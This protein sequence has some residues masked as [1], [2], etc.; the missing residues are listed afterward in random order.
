MLNIQILRRPGRAQPT[1]VQGGKAVRYLHQLIKI[2]ADHDNRRAFACQIHQRLP[3]RRGCG[4]VDT[5]GRLVH[6]QKLWL[7]QNFATDHKLLQVAARQRPCRIRGAGR[8]HVKLGNDLFGKAARLAPIQHTPLGKALT[9]RAGQHRIFRQAHV[10]GRRMAKP[11][12]RGGLNA[13]TPAFRDANPCQVR[14]IEIK[15]IA[16][17]GQ[18]AGQNAQKLVLTVASHTADAQDLARHHGKTQVFQRD[19]KLSDRRH[20]EVLGLQDHHI[21]VA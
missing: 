13:H 19:T 21:H 12:F 5:P 15:L 11:L 1:F 7:L 20:R 2:L 14:V 4:G 6:H 18:F 9:D 10:R 17:A 8:A 3:D 16:G